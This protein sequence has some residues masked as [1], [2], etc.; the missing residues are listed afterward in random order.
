MAKVTGI[1]PAAGVTLQATPTT[2]PGGGSPVPFRKAT[3]RKIEIGLQDQRVVTALPQPISGV[4]EGTGYLE[5]IDLEVVAVSAGNAAAVAYPGGAATDSPWSALQDIAFR[6]VGPDLFTLS[7]YDLYLLNLYGGFGQ[8]TAR[9]PAIFVTG[10]P[11]NYL[12]VIGAGATGGSIRYTLR[13]PCAINPRSLLGI[14][15]NQSQGTKY[16]LSTT[17]APNTAIW[18]VQPTNAPTFTITKYYNYASVPAPVDSLNRPQA[19][20]PPAYGVLHM[21]NSLRSEAA[22]LSGTGVQH[23]LRQLGNTTRLLILVFRLA[24]GLRSDLPLFTLATQTDARI[25]MRIG[26]DVII[27]ETAAHRRNIM[28]NRYHFDAPTG[29]LVYD[30]ISDF[31]DRPGYELGDDWL[32]LANIPNAQFEIAYPAFAGGPASLQIIS[33]MLVIP[34]TV[35]VQSFV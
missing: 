7:G 17:L 22:V 10:D 5:S 30:W 26:D 35:D 8:L 14:M 27:S 18:S 11:M 24:S 4:V 20:V 25:T 9:G 6:A 31:V 34:P 12:A 19:Q 29:V 16:Q 23:Y 28:W 21:V 13:L 15:G 1:T 32:N 33:D 2:Q 3:T